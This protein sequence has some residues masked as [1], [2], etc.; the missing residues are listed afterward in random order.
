MCVLLH[1]YMQ[2]EAINAWDKG[3]LKLENLIIA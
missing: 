1:G 2:S 3:D